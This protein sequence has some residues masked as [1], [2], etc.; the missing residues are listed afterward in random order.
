MRIR[1]SLL[2]WGVFL[3]LAGTVP[4]LVRGGYLDPAVVGR[5]WDLWPLLIV[6]VGISLILRRT[7]LDLLGGLVVAATFGLMA[8]A[9]LGGG[10][11]PLTSGV[12]GADQGATAFPARDGSF[13]QAGA[14]TLQADCASVTVGIG[15]GDA[16]HVEGRDTNGTGPRLDPT[17]RSLSV[18]SR[19]GDSGPFGGFGRREIWQVT[20]PD[21][22]KVDFDLELNAGDASVDLGG[23][24]IGSVDLEVNAGSA[25]LALGSVESIGDLDLSLNAGSLGLTLPNQSVTGTIEANAGSVKLCVPQGAAIRLRTGQSLVGSYAYAGHGLVQD[26]ST[27][28]TPGFESAAVRIDLQTSA[29]AGS[30]TLDPEGGCE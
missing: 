9:L 17:D 29:N 5:A 12:C 3:I 13:T 30:F 22:P 24:N 19:N 11:F 28:T 27:W 1:R 4:L 26:G 20:L 15:H 8:G 25:R 16:W 6:G 21:T 18:R 23:A 10:T 2:G 7:R 14:V